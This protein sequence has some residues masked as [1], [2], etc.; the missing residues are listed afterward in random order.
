[1]SLLPRGNAEKPT[2][3]GSALQADARSCGTAVC[4]GGCALAQCLGRPA[5]ARGCLVAAEER[6]HRHLPAPQTCG[7][8]TS[9]QKPRLNDCAQS[10]LYLPAEYEAPSCAT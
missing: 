7:L 1:M 6:M 10:K 5:A 4:G 3:R 2:Q 9:M 8:P